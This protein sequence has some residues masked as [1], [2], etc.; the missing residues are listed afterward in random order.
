MISNLQA[1]IRKQMLADQIA[2]VSKSYMTAQEIIARQDTIRSLLGPLFG[3]LESEY[4]RPLL[5][6]VFGLM[7]RAGQFEEVPD[8][9]LQI[10]FKPTFTGP[11][12]RA[13]KMERANVIM[14]YVQ[15]L[16]NLAQIDPSVLDTIDMTKVA[17]RYGYLTGVEEDLLRTKQEIDDIRRK[18]AEAQQAQQQALAAMPQQASNG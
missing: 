7:Y 2:P 3:R 8:S 16:S 13:Q 5:E 1:S 14:N 18:R 11:H 17:M 10:E 15:Q 12:A 9:L 6:R 4:L